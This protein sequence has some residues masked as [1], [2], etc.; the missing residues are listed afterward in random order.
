M[1]GYKLFKVELQC[2]GGRTWRG[3]GIAVDLGGYGVALI[4][5]S[6]APIGGGLVHLCT[7]WLVWCWM[8][9]EGALRVLFLVFRDLCFILVSILLAGIRL[10]NVYVHDAYHCHD[11]INTTPI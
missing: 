7:L 11:R 3:D 5:I 4:R 2:L 6:L 10:R 9:L 8:P 1:D